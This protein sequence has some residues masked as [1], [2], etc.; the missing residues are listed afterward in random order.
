MKRLRK[1]EALLV[2]EINRLDTLLTRAVKLREAKKTRLTIGE[3]EKLDGSIKK[4]FQ[5]S[6]DNLNRTLEAVQSAKAA[7]KAAKKAKKKGQL[8]Q[9]G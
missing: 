1:L 6:I 8:A 5:L 7:A 4:H 2:K 3:L 9:V